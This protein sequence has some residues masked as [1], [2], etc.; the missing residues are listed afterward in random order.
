MNRTRLLFLT[1]ALTTGIAVAGDPLQPGLVGRYYQI[2]GALEDFPSLPAGQKPSVERVDKDIN[3]ASTL[4][5]FP[6][7]KLVDNF[8]VNWT[9]VLR[10]PKDGNYTFHLE[11]D[12]GS[13]L[14]IDGKE[15]VDHSG[16]HDMT[17]MSGRAELKA[18]D[19]EIKV[20]FF[21]AE[22]EAGCILSW[23]T[24]GLAKAI[25]PAAALF[26]KAA[27]GEPGLLAEYY[28]TEDGAEDFPDFPASKSPDLKRVDKIVNFESTQD[29]WPGTDFKDFFYIRWTGTIRVPA[30]GRYTFFLD[31]DDG[32]RLFIDGKPVVD[33]GGAHAM[34]EVSGNVELTAGDHAL[35]IEFFEKDIDAGCRFLWKSDKIQKQIV[36]AEV[37]FH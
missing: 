22:E 28:R 3:F 13:R 24:A 31:S 1:A 32:S 10:I 26:H 37:L 9:G 35:K 15:V 23:E 16:T 7:T 21:D 5:A 19:H 11:S 2:S 33:N 6:G 30:D 20:E 14:Y 18:G 27:A 25:V 36:P 34:E 12:D 4:E 29:N 8:Y 17:E